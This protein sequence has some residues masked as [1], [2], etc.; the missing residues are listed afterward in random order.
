MM[1]KIVS[2]ILVAL[3][4]AGCGRSV[5]VRLARVNALAEENL[6]D[7]AMQVLDSID[8]ASLSG[9]Y[10]RRYYDLLTIKTRDKADLSF[11]SDSLALS[12]MEYFKDHGTDTVRAEA[13]YYAGRVARVLGDSP[14]A[15]D[16]MQSALDCLD[17]SCAR[18]KGKISSQMG[19]IFV[20][21]RLYEQAKHFFNKAV[22]YNRESKDSLAL[23]YNIRDLGDVYSSLRMNDSALVRFNEALKIAKTSYPQTRKE[24][25]TL[26][27]I[28]DFYISNKEYSHAIET[29][30][31]IEPFLEEVYVT[32]FIHITAMQVYVIS[33]DYHK[34]EKTAKE[35]L[36]RNTL[37]CNRYAYNALAEI[38]KLQKDKDATYKYVIKYVNTLDS[39]ND[40]ASTDAV[41]HQNSIYNYKL[42]EQKNLLLEKKQDSLIISVL[43]LVIIVSA[44]VM[45]TYFI[46]KHLKS[47]NKKLLAENNNLLSTNELQKLELSQQLK[48]IKKLESDIIAINADLFNINITDVDINRQ[49]LDS[50]KEKARSVDP[51]KYKVA[52]EIINSNIY[53]WISSILSSNKL[54]AISRL[55]WNELD[56]II[57]ESSKDF[58]LKLYKLNH[59]LSEHEYHICLLIKS[60]FNNSDIAILTHKDKASISNAR[61][62]LYKKIFFCE[63]DALDLDKLI[64]LL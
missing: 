12:V 6:A 37:Y 22:V 8:R 57:N 1:H 24:L 18:L 44:L 36:K 23:L 60:G 30:Q 11:E 13:Y 61:K 27:L 34:A 42:K 19:Q 3:I 45:I 10:N 4:L 20:Q 56:N 62:R 31:N 38:A 48:Q 46:Y 16:Y 21:F 2:Y 9:E 29:F 35:L 15:L 33:G 50:I 63:G 41:I 59:K 14:Q 39:I 5:D 49:I 32:D 43:S 64:Y 52:Q 55:H 47:R 7:S 53:S 17:D 26:A 58:K 54:V 28:T 25:E 51:S 40:N